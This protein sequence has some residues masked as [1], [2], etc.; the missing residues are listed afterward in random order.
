MSIS[1][2][3]HTCNLLRKKTHGILSTHSQDVPGYPFGSLVNFCLDK[4]GSPLLQLSDLAQHTKNLAA[5]PKVSLTVIDIKNDDVQNATR[6]T[7]LANAH[8]LIKPD[9][10][11]K[12][13]F[14]AHFPEAKSCESMGFFLYRLDIARIRYIGGFGKIAWIK[15]SEYKL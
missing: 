10:D 15:P 7:V 2:V 6:I 12:E 8:K 13:R 3:E 9:T 5:N 14:W 11:S 4:N 1:F